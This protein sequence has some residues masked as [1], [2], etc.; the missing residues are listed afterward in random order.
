MFVLRVISVLSKVALLNLITISSTWARVI[1]IMDNEVGRVHGLSSSK[2]EFWCTINFVGYSVR[3]KIV[4]VYWCWCNPWPAFWIIVCH[5][6]GL[7]WTMYVF[8][9]NYLEVYLYF[10]FIGNIV[11]A[12][13]L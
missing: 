3:F 7:V 12:Q 11:R 9:F 5:N 6:N 4:W 1:D 2:H 13:L 8:Y 10:F